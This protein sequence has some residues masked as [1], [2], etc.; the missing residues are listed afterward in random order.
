LLA[1]DWKKD[2]RDYY[3]FLEKN[4]FLHRIEEAIDILESL[5]MQFEHQRVVLPVK[6]QKS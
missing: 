1:A 2:I 6:Q 5:K 3:D 4:S